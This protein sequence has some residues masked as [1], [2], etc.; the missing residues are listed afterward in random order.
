MS[1]VL[2][3]ATEAFMDLMNRVFR[4]YLDMFVMVFIHDILIYSR[5]AN[6]YMDQLRIV[7]QILKD[8]QRFAKLSKSEFSLRFI[9]FLGYIVSSKEFRYILRRLMLSRVGQDL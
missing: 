2:T 8:Q 4:K 3:N 7:L 5:S 9:A 1:F 6:E